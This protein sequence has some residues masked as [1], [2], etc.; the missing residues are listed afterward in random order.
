MPR[1]RISSENRP[2]RAVRRALISAAL[3]AWLS[4]C[5]T[6]GGE[7]APAQA[8]TTAP[9]YNLVGYSPAFKAGY[10]DACANPR[11]KSDARFKNEEDYRMGWNDGSSICKR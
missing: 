2:A 7:S 9:R 6:T 11:R 5:A 4:G 10:G 8:P 3:L 1:H